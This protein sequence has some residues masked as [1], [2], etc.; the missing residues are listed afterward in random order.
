MSIFFS[1]ELNILE[2]VLKKF[3]SLSTPE[4]I[5]IA[6]D[7]KAWLD[8]VKNKAIIDFTIYAPQLSAL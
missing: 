8:N 3:K 7:E 6:H 4:I 1:S 2:T 5:K